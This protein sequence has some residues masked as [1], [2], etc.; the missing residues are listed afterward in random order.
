M[1]IKKLIGFGL[2]L[3]VIFSGCDKKEEINED[4]IASTPKSQIRTFNLK[5]TDG[6]FIT[7]EY[8]NGK[9]NF[10]DFPNKVVLLNFWA[11][12]CPPCKAEIP[13]LNNLVQKYKDEFIVLG[14]LVE[15]D[16]NNE[17]LISFMK[18]HQM[19]YPVT[20]GQENFYLAQAVG[21][22]SSIPA[23]FMFDKTGKMV[24]NY[25]GAVH[26][27]ILESDINKYKGNKQ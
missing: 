26:E 5:K 3:V 27:E 9:W 22:V 16:K 12:W 19:Q 2:L 17:D 18:S 20:N 13:H 25:V 15:E 23:M 1:N 14:V 21:G 7:I 4:I 24:M 11:T 10:K 6:S 8:E